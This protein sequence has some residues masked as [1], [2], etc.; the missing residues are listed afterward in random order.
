MVLRLWLDMPNNGII[1]GCKQRSC[2]RVADRVATSSNRKKEKDIFLA[3]ASQVLKLES[4]IDI[5]S[6]F[7]ALC[8]VRPIKIDQKNP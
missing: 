4:A 8:G 2:Q 6:C 3:I 5:V 1:K 7:E